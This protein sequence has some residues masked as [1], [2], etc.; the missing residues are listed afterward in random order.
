MGNGAPVGRDVQWPGVT[1]SSLDELAQRVREAVACGD[2]ELARE[3][4]EV[5]SCTDAGHR[6]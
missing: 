6:D 3:L 1:P 5:A 4:I 2:F